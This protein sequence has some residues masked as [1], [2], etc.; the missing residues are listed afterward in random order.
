M[1]KNYTFEQAMKAYKSRSPEFQRII[2]RVASE[3][4]RGYGFEE[5]GTSDINHEICNICNQYQGDFDA[6]LLEVVE[7]WGAQWSS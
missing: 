5:I 1:N 6:L 2:R 3:R 7:E 4:L